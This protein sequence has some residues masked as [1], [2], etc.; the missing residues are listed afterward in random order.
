MPGR[1]DPCPCGSGKKYKKCCGAPPSPPP[2]WVR[3]KGDH[4]AP[5]RA[6]AYI[7]KIGQ[8]R[9]DFCRQYF[10]YKQTL[11]KD[12]EKYLSGQITAREEKLTCRKGCHYCCFEYIGGTLHE[13]EA[14]VYYL[15]QNQVAFDDF[16]RGYAGW[17]K[18]VSE[19]ES[20]FDNIKDIYKRGA[21]DGFTEKNI[22]DFRD[23]SVLY[24]KQC[25]PCP[26]LVDGLCSI[27]EIR[28]RVCASVVATTPAEWCSPLNDNEPTV[29]ICRVDPKELE[30]PFFREPMTQGMTSI[31]VSVYEILNGGYVWLSDIPGLD[32]LDDEAMSDPEVRQ[33]LQRYL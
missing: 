16:L 8:M 29:L 21:A 4:M 25:I 5:H 17:R 6:I 24:S 33:I 3:E 31:P 13:C 11:F 12:M 19:Q 9:A 22:Q 23:A 14:I 10:T 32:G 1:N 2:A 7:G 15:Y 18:K 20:L 28:P 26:F 30:P 27:Y